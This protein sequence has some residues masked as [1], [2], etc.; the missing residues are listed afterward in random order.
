M[1]DNTAMEW[2]WQYQFPPFFTLQPHTETRTR[3]LSTWHNLVLDYFRTT[4]QYKLDLGEAQRL[5]LFNNT[6]INRKC[7][8]EFILIILEELEKTKNSAPLDKTRNRWEIYWHTLQE[9]ADII[10]SYIVNRGA[11]GSVLTFYELTHGD[12]VTEEEFKGMD[13]NILLKVLRVL[14]EQRKCT[15]ML[16]DDQQGVKFF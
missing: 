5:A 11:T 9:W 6:E 13:D 8:R 14:E 3:Q 4:R 1:P 12:D 7:D 15:V 16:Y 10:Y 2:P